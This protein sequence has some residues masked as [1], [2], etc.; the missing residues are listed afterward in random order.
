MQDMSIF[1][2]RAA[3]IFYA[4]GLVHALLAVL[5]RPVT[6]FRPALWT[7][8]AGLI[9]HGVALTERLLASRSAPTHGFHETFSACAFL[10]GLLFILLYRRYEFA[11]ASVILFPFVFLMTLVGATEV[12]VSRW[13]NPQ[14]RDL[15]LLAHIALV[16]VGYAALVL[17]AVASIFYLIQEHN[18]KQKRRAKFFHRMPPL[19]TLDELIS[20]S[21]AWGFVCITLATIAG[22]TWA[23]VESGTRWIGQP[24]VA[25]S[26][27]TWGFY[28]LMVFLRVSAGWRG[29]KAAFMTLAVLGCSALTWAAHVGLRSLLTQ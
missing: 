4:V 8:S 19:S 7:F 13:S 14:V 17:T 15:W 6:L 28:L 16:L 26:F 24:E 29:R 27:V 11:S 21:M 23:F 22:S 1:W 3:A 25:I 20:R 12:P 18:L 10:V 9:L 5:R 2:L